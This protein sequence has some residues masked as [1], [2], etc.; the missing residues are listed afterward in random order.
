MKKVTILLVAM[1]SGCAA[2]FQGQEQEIAIEPV[3]TIMKT[4]CK[5][6][7]DKGT[8]YV[9]DGVMKVKRS[10]KPLDIVCQNRRQL[11]KL[12]VDSSADL[13]YIIPN[14]LLDYCTLSCVMDYGTR[15][16]GYSYPDEIKLMMDFR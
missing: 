6:S 5:A 9:R 7:N 14:I 3:D 8:Y 16:T 1:L 11:A 4:D 13:V 12:S 2:V 10:T 15:Q